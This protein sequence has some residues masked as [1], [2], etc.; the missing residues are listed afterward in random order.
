[1]PDQDVE[2]IESAEDVPPSFESLNDEIK[3]I[4]DRL[5]SGEHSLESL[6]SDYETGIKLLE[7]AQNLLTA[8][9]QRITMLQ[10]Q[11]TSETSPEQ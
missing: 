1:M 2:T 6:V 9:E 7:R 4:V 11:T 10:L 3:T 5:E 8:A